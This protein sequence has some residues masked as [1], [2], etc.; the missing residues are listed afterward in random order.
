MKHCSMFFMRTVLMHFFNSY[1]LN[2][3][4]QISLLIVFILFISMWS[5]VLFIFLLTIHLIHENLMIFKSKW[6]LAFAFLIFLR[7][8]AF[9]VIPSV[10][11]LIA[12]KMKVLR[13]IFTNEQTYAVH[14]EFFSL[15]F[16]VLMTWWSF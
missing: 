11:V 16:W 4:L 7:R 14:F 12:Q 1:L 5:V 13:L 10:F 8:C 9:I 15:V 3:F 6:I 2:I